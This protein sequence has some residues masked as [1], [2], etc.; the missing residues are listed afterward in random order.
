MPQTVCVREVL[1]VHAAVPQ[2]SWVAKLA[3]IQTALFGTLGD[4]A[5]CRHIALANDGGAAAAIERDTG[6]EPVGI[7][8]V[9]YLLTIIAHEPCVSVPVVRAHQVGRKLCT[10]Q[11]ARR[12]FGRVLKTGEERR[13]VPRARGSLRS[14]DAQRGCGRDK[15]EKARYDWERT[16]RRAVHSR[17]RGSCSS[18]SCA[19]FGPQIKSRGNKK[20]LRMVQITF[21]KYR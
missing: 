21:I 9:A 17:H 10:P 18:S 16:G 8:G 12:D 7:E 13:A 3:R 14:V 2:C 6:N 1:E 19:G 4:R 11:L 15:N 20:R 5:V